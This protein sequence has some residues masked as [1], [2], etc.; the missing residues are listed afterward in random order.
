MDALGT[1]DTRILARRLLWESIGSKHALRAFRKP[2]SDAEAGQIATLQTWLREAPPI[3]ATTDPPSALGVPFEELWLALADRAI[4]KLAE[5][6][7]GAVAGAY[8]T[9]R[10]GWG[11]HHGLRRDLIAELV[12]KLAAIGEAVLWLEFNRRRTPGDIVLAHIAADDRKDLPRSRYLAFLEEL[13]ADGLEPIVTEYPVLGRHLSTAVQQWLNFSDDL[14]VR[15]HDDRPALASSFGVAP[16]ARLRSMKGGLSDPHRGGQTVA[17]LGFESSTQGRVW[18]VVYKPKDL[19]LDRIFQSLVANLPA[20]SGE[21]EPLRAITVL[22]RDGYGYMEHVLRRA[23]HDER[24]LARFYR[25]AGRLTAFL[26]LVGGSDCHFENLIAAST[27]LLLID[28][29]TLFE[30]VPR[31]EPDLNLASAGTDL[32]YRIGG[33][34]L[35]LG[36]LPHWGFIGDARTPRDLSALGVA[37]PLQRR[38]KAIGWKALN[39]DG[40]FAAEVERTVQMPSSLPVEI[41]VPNRL[42]DF[43][44]DFCGGFGDQLTAIRAQRDRWIGDTGHL[45]SVRHLRRR[46]I[47]RPTWFYAWLRAQ[48]L[49]PPWQRSELHQRL[50]LE[51]L[52]RSYLRHTTKPASW[53]Q[54]ASELRQLR[55][56]DI[57][58]FEEAIDGLDLILPDGPTIPDFFLT[59]GYE[60]ARQRI[61]QLE[62]D[63]IALQLRL[64]RGVVAAKDMRMSHAAQASSPPIER[65]EEG[66]IDALREAGELARLMAEGAIEDATGP[67]EWLGFEVTEDLERSRYGALGPSLYSGR[68]GIALFLAALARRDGSDVE[69]SRRFALGAVRDL[70]DADRLSN[71]D[72]CHRWW[73]DQPLGL[74]GSGGCLLTLLHLRQLLPGDAAILT[75]TLQ[76]LIDGLSPELILDEERLDVMNG[77]AGLIG[78]LLQCGIPRATEVAMQAGE[79]LVAR[80]EPSGGWPSDL[81]VAQP[82]LGFSH[83][84]SGILSALARL[85]A[86]GGGSRY[87]QGVQRA[88]A[89]ERRQF[90]PVRANWPDFR[91]LGE[92]RFPVSW[93]HGAPGVALSRLCLIGAQLCDNQVE[94][95]LACALRSTE[96]LDL[97]GDSI[98]CGRFGRAVILR[99]AG[100]REDEVGWAASAQRLTRHGIAEKRRSGA[101]SFAETQGL[102]TGAAG[103]GLALLGLSSKEDLGLL[104][105]VLSAGLHEPPPA[106]VTPRG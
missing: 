9:D 66:K 64:I 24:E 69:R 23:C 6:L 22:V 41:G 97:P 85:W 63:S 26:Y 21:D 3:G 40:M 2:T 39:T 15:V 28:A 91:G 58:F 84:T 16:D 17:V 87:A 55:V 10:P 75:M 94:A 98:C 34:V 71:Q 11:T 51:T 99:L 18:H 19:Q 30:G 56:L 76:T 50:K 35:R 36:M 38:A 96:S 59:S 77:C 20:P 81:T 57:P 102:F 88:L 48:L 31:E 12:A 46:F 33:S 72:V 45:D 29:E 101:Y 95:E 67:V 106:P 68:G 60:A 79:I 105:S 80:Q 62:E 65:S 32:F 27:E 82:L 86:E 25:N 49:E 4:G 93:C 1:Q 54:F 92:A 13:R 47:S 14:L 78:P 70:L 5:Q 83:G 90:D 42:V 89:Y 104:A 7:P 103:V 43:V 74:A 61:R 37:P 44:E 8:Q 73:R 53:P 52:A 100:Q